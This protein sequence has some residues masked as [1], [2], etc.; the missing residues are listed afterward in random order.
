[1]SKQNAKWISTAY[2]DRVGQILKDK[3]TICSGATMGEQVAMEAYVRSIV[4]EADDTGTVLTGVDQGFHN[5]LYY[6]RK[7]ANVEQIHDIVVLDQGT[8]IVNNLGA[9]RTKPL[10]QWGHGKLLREIKDANGRN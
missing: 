5:F 1:M 6:S 9:M 2:G 7:L 4:A 10:E 8:G 3:P